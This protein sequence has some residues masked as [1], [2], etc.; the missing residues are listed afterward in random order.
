MNIPIGTRLTSFDEQTVYLDSS[1]HCLIT[2]KSGVGKS[3]LLFNLALSHIRNGDGVLLI[4]PHGD[5]ADKIL[6]HIPRS[7][8]RDVIYIDPLAKRVPGLNI[9]DYEKPEDRE[10]AVQS[11]L[12]MAKSISGE[13][14]GPETER[15]LNA[16]ADAVVR[17][18]P[19]PTLIPIH[20]F[21]MR[22]K[23]RKKLLQDSKDP[24]LADFLSQYDEELRPS[25]RMSKFSPAVNKT[26]KFLRPYIRTIVGQQDSVD[27]KAAM[28]SQK[29]VIARLP[30]GHLGSITASLIGSIIVSHMSISAL[31]RKANRT[32][33]YAFIDEV[34]N[35]VHGVDLPTVLA[36]SRKYGITLFLAAQNLD[37]LPYPSAVFGNC[38]NLISFRMGG[39]DAEIIAQE[40]GNAVSNTA[41]V[42]L[43]DRTFCASLL[44]NG[45]PNLYEQVE[46]LPPLKRQPDDAGLRDVIKVARM[47]YGKNRK[48]TDAQILKF[49]G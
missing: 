4:D 46:A 30:K 23:F 6:S 43:A 16:A 39:A 19:K 28:D 11:F 10:R 45:S 22:P 33:F 13:S 7:R 41:I 8:I 48:E 2:G 26:D 34:S 32:P 37:Q 27:F 25:E 38:S 9:F 35:F 3:T 21:L 15:V 14:W 12:T 18:Y 42:N 47:R 20:L 49:L 1:R 31:Q 36:E 17:S 24:L 40:L 29:I 44:E 5:L